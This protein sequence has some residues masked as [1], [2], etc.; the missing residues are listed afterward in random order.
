MVKTN[1][2]IKQG[3]KTFLKQE[4]TYLGIFCTLFAVLLL[5]TVDMPW[6]EGSFPV[7]YTTIAFLIG[8]GTSMLAGFIG[9][10]IATT[11]NVKVTYLCNISIHDG[12]QVAF[13]GGQVLGFGLVGL[14][15]I[16][17]EIIILSYRPSILDS[18]GEQAEQKAI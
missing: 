4:Y 10:M 17:L 16:I 14:A 18:L 11:A 13:N 3:A 1:G 9:M 5:C 7:P 2:F 15:L 6:A 8:A 12:F